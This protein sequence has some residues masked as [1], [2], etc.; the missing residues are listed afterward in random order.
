VTAELEFTPAQLARMKSALFGSE[1]NYFGKDE[2]TPQRAEI[3]RL[4]GVLTANEQT[5]SDLRF[6]LSEADREIAK[7]RDVLTERDQEIEIL[8]GELASARTA[9]GWM[10]MP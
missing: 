3:E 8:R 6:M 10:V 2:L 1:E 5:I 9:L 4:R 7:L